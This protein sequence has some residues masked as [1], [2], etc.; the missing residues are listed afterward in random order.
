MSKVANSK[1]SKTGE[2]EKQ[3]KP[4]KAAAAVETQEVQAQE[5][6]GKASIHPGYRMI[7]V[8]LPSGDSFVTRSTYPKDTLRLEIDP[9]SHPAWKKGGD[10][11][12]FNARDEKIAAFNSTF[13]AVDFL[14]LANK[15]KDQ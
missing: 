5:R 4:R 9:S 10:G 2:A 14:G 11:T 12:M 3:K 7:K 8:V 13:G 15:T 1:Q 6:I